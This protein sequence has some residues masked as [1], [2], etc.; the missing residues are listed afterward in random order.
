M[1]IVLHILRTS[2][3]C[4]NYSFNIKCGDWKRKCFRWNATIGSC[5]VCVSFSP[6]DLNESQDNHRIWELYF[7]VVR[8]ANR[9]MQSGV[10]GGGGSNS[11]ECEHSSYC[12]PA[13]QTI[14]LVASVALEWVI[15]FHQDQWENDCAASDRYPC[16]GTPCEWRAET[17]WSY[18]S[19]TTETEFSFKGDG[20]KGD[21]VTSQIRGY[22]DDVCQLWVK[23]CCQIGRTDLEVER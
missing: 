16:A 15:V 3:L 13:L 10:R 1:F 6:F 4:S 11:A 17:M 12:Y 22:P 5:G 14:S 21:E 18:P 20:P 7:G 9:E 8:P 23:N 19:R 2:K